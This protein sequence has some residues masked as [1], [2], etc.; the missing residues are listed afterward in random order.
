MAAGHLIMLAEYT[1]L[2]TT[3]EG[4][5]RY[6]VWALDYTHAQRQANIL[7]P[8]WRTILIRKSH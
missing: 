6:T 2:V 3:D 8:R 7:S 4:F 1:V 5:E